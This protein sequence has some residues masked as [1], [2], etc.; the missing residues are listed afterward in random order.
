MK[1]SDIVRY[2]NQIDEL[3]ASNQYRLSVDNH[4]DFLI[5]SVRK[6][7]NIRNKF[8]IDIQHTINNVHSSLAALENHLDTVANEVSVLI[9]QMQPPYFERS[10]RWYTN[11]MQHETAQYILERRLIPGTDEDR[12]ALWARVKTWADWRYPV[13]CIR[14]G[15]EEFVNNLVAGSPLYIVDQ[16]YELLE[17]TLDRFNEKYRR[18]IRP[19]VIKES[20]TEPLMPFLPN[21]QFGLIF[22]YN[23]FNFRPLEAMR[24]YFTEILNKLRP[25]GIFIF[26]INNCDNAHPV[27]LCENNYACYT[28]GEMVLNLATMLGFEHRYTYDAR[29]QLC[30]YELAKP[31]ELTTLRG[32]QSLAK[33][34][35]K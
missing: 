32:G 33:I 1:L 21:G 6:E 34:M 35:P 26:T 14:P 16:F 13:L 15:N 18:H 3:R 29:D 19:Y 2:K 24:H 20:E 22:A 4:L 27:A 5:R 28:P 9:E 31:G 8:E 7:V 11:E 12:E 17:P 23:Y 10:Y 30:W 25:G